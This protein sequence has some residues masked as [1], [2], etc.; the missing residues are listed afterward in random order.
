VA[1]RSAPEARPTAVA[2]PTRTSWASVVALMGAGVVAAAQIG[3]ASAAL[4]VL[5]DEFGLSSTTAAWY[6]STV[7]ALSAVGGALLGW[8][9]QTLGLARQVRIGLV[10]IVLADL[11]GALAG[12]LAGLLAARVGEGVGLVMV[13]LAA[14]GLLSTVS[15]PAHRRLVAGMWGAYMP[16]GAGLAALLVPP[17][18]AAVGWPGASVCDAVVAVGVL[19][20][21]V[22]WVP[23]SA[24]ARGP[25]ALA[26]LL[27]ALRS[28]TVLVLSAVFAVYAGQY[29]AVVGL[30]PAE[31]VS[32]EGL[33][34]A[35]AGSVSGLVFLV[36][37]P[38]NLFGAYL[39]HRGVAPRTLITVGSCCMVVTVWGVFADGLPLAVRIASAVVFSA[40]AGL[41]P[42]AAFAGLAAVSAGTPSAGPAVGLVT[43]GSGIGQLLGPPLVVTVG[44][45]FATA[46]ARPAVLTGL[47]VVAVVAASALPRDER[48][49]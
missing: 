25:V 30:F 45:A 11:G 39:L 9:G 34:L 41:V 43:Q 35:A 6:L 47:A 7:S 46:A 36:N 33:S 3:G 15:T 19:V 12:S 31:L 29:L 24:A 40:T 10:V 49:R 32:G 48:I 37:A 5:Q 8:L 23:S 14:P 1:R 21:V 27:G 38:G 22:R 26:G 20:A 13:I 4:P 18:I 17:A 44:A 42:S 16:V 2:A 28:R